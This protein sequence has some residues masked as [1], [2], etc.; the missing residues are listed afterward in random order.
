MRIG[1]ID[2]DLLDNGTRHPNLACEKMSGYYKEQGHDVHLITDYST[3]ADYDE[4]YMSCVFDFTRIPL[5]G[6]T[7]RH[8]HPDLA[9][10]AHTFFS[11]RRFITFSTVSL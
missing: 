7:G 3:L 6:L 4:V 1:I 9:R 10:L 11:F 5:E 8:D 2:A